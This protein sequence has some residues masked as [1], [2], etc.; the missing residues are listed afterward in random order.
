MLDLTLQTGVY[1]VGISFIGLT[2]WHLSLR[3]SQEYSGHHY[4]ENIK[5]IPILGHGLFI[6]NEPRKYLKQ[7][8][9]AA[10][11]TKQ[12]KKITFILWFTPVNPVVVAF[13]PEG[14]KKLATKELNN[15]SWW[16][17]YAKSWLGTGLLT[18]GD[19]K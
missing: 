7:L 14:A 8:M 9:Q 6:E 3:F 18:S 19:E 11:H 2:V 17:T 5:Y 15:K 4:P 16:Y 1:L 10:E 12:A 13:C